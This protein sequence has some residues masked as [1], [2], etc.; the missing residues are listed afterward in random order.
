M[1]ERKLLKFVFVL[2]SQQGLNLSKC[3]NGKNFKIGMVLCLM[4]LNEYL[5]K[6]YDFEIERVVTKRII[7]TA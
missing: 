2:N 3:W 4:R 6:L 7:I 5:S 1:T